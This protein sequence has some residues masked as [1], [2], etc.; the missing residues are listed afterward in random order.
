[1]RSSLASVS[2]I[3]RDAIVI[4]LASVATLLAN[5][6]LYAS[7]MTSYEEHVRPILKTHCFHCHGE[8]EIKKAGVDLRLHRLI[9]AGGKAG[10]II[11][12]GGRKGSLMY[13]LVA[14]GEM[15]E[16]EG[17]ALSPQEV[18]T[19]GRWLDEGGNTVSEGYNETI[20]IVSFAFPGLTMGC[21]EGHDHRFDPILQQDYY[22]MR[23][24]IEPAL[25]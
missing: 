8:E 21:A 5:V 9:M 14:S 1:M 18:E 15:P 13:E 20:K 6:G 11:V 3:R 17:K 25:D 4:V 23:A 24:F 10:A 22:A 16:E 12:P 7:S 19:I 2:I